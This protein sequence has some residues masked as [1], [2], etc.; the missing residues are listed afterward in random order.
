MVAPSAPAP[1]LPM[2][3]SEDEQDWS[4]TITRIQAS[5]SRHPTG[6]RFTNPA[7]RAV[8]FSVAAAVFPAAFA[9][10]FAASFDRFWY[11][12]LSRCFCQYRVK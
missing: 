5:A 7:A 1:A 9:L 10:C 4:R 8:S 6:W 3:T 2:D 11:C 12:L